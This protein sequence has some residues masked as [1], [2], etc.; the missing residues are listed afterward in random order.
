MQPS[1]SKSTALFQWTTKQSKSHWLEQTLFGLGTY[2]P[3][4]STSSVLATPK[5]LQTLNAL[6][7]TC[8]TGLWT[9]LMLH[10]VN[11]AVVTGRELR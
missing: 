6:P 4:P 11:A 10:G 9:L 1:F 2:L 7:G 8:G 3:I 5:P